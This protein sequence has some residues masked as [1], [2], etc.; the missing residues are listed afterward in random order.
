V[1]TTEPGSAATVNLG[2]EELLRDPFRAYA[3]IREQAPLVRAVMPG[4]EPG[5]LVTRYEDVKLVMGDPRFVH[6]PRNVPG[7]GVRDLREQVQRARGMPPEFMKTWL[8]G[9]IEVDGADHSRLRGL[10]SHAFTMRGVARLR[11]RVEEITEDLLDRLPELAHDGVVDLIRHFA[12][13]LSSTVLCDVVGIP[14]E[15]RRQW[16]EWREVVQ[17]INGPGKVEAWRRVFGYIQELIER[18]RRE[19][20]DDLTSELVRAN[21]DAA[22]GSPAGP[23]GNRV[24]DTEMVMMIVMLGLTSHQTAH[25]I[26]NGTVALLTHPEQLALLRTNPDLMPRAVHEMLRW[27]SPTQV[28]PRLRYATEDIEVGGMPVRQGEAVWV[29]LA[30]ANHDPRVFENPE[31]F[32]ITRDPERTRRASGV[33]REGRAV[34]VASEKGERPMSTDRRR[35]THVAFGHGPH[36][37]IGSELARLEG[38]VVFERLPRRYPDLALAVAPGELDREPL[39]GHWRLAALPVR[40]GAD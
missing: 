37:C 4:V 20:A 36:H 23:G 31:R 30:A 19:P 27:C 28:T 29:V 17:A 1:T 12:Y 5:W 8:T 32:D 11:P 35:V 2:D 10:V 24:S 14:E 26:G 16:Q 13:P 15:D 25:L 39:P 21:S 38:E 7:T 33:A 9:M 6:D 22:D 40:L 3:R 18:R 34:R